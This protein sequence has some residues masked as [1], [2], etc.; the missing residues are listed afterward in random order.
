MRK[1]NPALCVLALLASASA[2]AFA[3]CGSGYNHQAAHQS[4]LQQINNCCPMG[5]YITGITY[6]SISGGVVAE[7]QAQCGQGLRPSGPWN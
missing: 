6:H 4:V 2:V 7:A 1:R 3:V 5:G